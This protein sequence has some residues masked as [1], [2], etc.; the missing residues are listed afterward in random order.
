M[1]E[2]LHSI[3]TDVNARSTSA[4]KATLVKTSS[5]GTPWYNKDE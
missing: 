5:A 4:V 2:T 1:I 3:L